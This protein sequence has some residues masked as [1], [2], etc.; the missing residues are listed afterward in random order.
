MGNMVYKDRRLS[1]RICRIFLPALYFLSS[2]TALCCQYRIRSQFW[3][4]K[5]RNWDYRVSVSQPTS[6]HPTRWVLHLRSRFYI[7]PG[8]QLCGVRLGITRYET[9]SKERT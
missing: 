6:V 1:F 8:Y 5:R 2:M 7:V 4:F 9:L 3:D